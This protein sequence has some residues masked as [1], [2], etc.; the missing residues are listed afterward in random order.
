MI[1]LWFAQSHPY[2]LAACIG[3]VGMDLIYTLVKLVLF[4]YYLVRYLVTEE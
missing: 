3:Y 1:D 4:G 2:L